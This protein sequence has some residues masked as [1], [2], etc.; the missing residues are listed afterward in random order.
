MCLNQ[1]T[2]K[3]APLLA[4]YLYTHKRLD[5]PGI[6]SF[7]LDPL[8]IAEPAHTKQGKPVNIEG[9]SFENN[10]AIKEVTGL[11]SYISAQTGKMKALAAADLN[12]HIELAIQFLNI[13][14]PFLFE[15]IGNLA[16]IKSGIF[17]FTSGH[18]M[19][20]TMKEYSVKEISVTSSTEDSFT[21]YK[22]IFSSLKEKANWKRPVAL[23]FLLTGF[24]FAIWIGYKMY[25]KTAEINNK[26]TFE[27]KTKNKNNPIVLKYIDHTRKDSVVEIAHTD[28]PAGNYKFVLEISGAKSA[29]ARFSRLKTFQWNVEM[30]TKDSLHK[31]F[32]LLPASVADT[33]RML[34][35]L[36]KLNGSRVYLEL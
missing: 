22:N 14:K 29:F 24:A 20:E 26:I 25:K 19:P 5:L 34:D 33:S 36:S 17:A 11:I 7:L 31:I 30:E 23:L 13:G 6:G 4:Q 15:G 28:I 27:E 35:S 12:S 3:L 9:I 18:V 16:K 2:L 8:V 1:N 32:M 21:E 10:A